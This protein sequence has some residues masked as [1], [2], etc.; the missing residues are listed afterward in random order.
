MIFGESKPE[1]EVKLASTGRE[2]AV[3]PLAVPSIA[4][5]GAMLAAVMQTENARFS[6]WEQVQVSAMM[7]AVLL[8]ALVLMLA[9]SF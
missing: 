1:Q 7:I 3:F 6:I 9:A 4:G 8:V 5:P 2:T